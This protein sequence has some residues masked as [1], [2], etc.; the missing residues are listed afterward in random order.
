MAAVDAIILMGATGSSAVLAFLTVWPHRLDGFPRSVVLISWMLAVLAII[1]TRFSGHF[2]RSMALYGDLVGR[3]GASPAILVG[4]GPFLGELVHSLFDRPD[5]RIRPVAVIDLEGKAG[6]SRLSGIPVRGTLADL[7]SMATRR[8]AGLIIL[9]LPPWLPDRAGVVARAAA[10]SAHLGL[11]LRVVPTL[12]ESLEGEVGGLVPRPADPNDLLNRRPA[13]IDL[14]AASA[15]LTGARVLVTGASGSI[16]SELCRQVAGLAPR[17]LVLL[18]NEEN[19]LYELELELRRSLPG[20]AMAVVVAD[21]RDRAKMARVFNDLRPD[22]VFHAAAHK[23]VPLMELEPDEAVK[24]NIAGTRNVAELAVAC[25][26]KRFVFI[27]T[28]KAVNPS[29]VM[30]ASKR[31]AEHIIRSM[32]GN[33]GETRLCSV[34]FGNVLGSKGSVVPI[35]EEQIAHGRPLTITHPEMTRYFMTIPEAARLVIQAGAMTQG[36]EVFALDMGEPVKII[37]LAKNL[38]RLKGLDPD[39]DLRF[40]F[41]GVRPGEKLYEELLTAPELRTTTKHSR[42]FVARP[43]AVDRN[44]LMRDLREL[45]RLGAAVEPAMIVAKLHEMVPGYRAG[46]LFRAPPVKAE[47]KVSRRL[48]VVNRA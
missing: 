33:P 4:A 8:R 40:E 1:A 46:G 15:Y 2:F 43:D 44:R 29:S 45:E 17:L 21:I 6:G 19:G 12:R 27:S 48:R 35:F 10:V 7:E 22:V 13:E 47:S 14:E 9:A 38:A 16:G 32:H 37:D 20:Q 5:L 30:G 36:G 11:A 41:I 42:V 28:D 31:V 25:K 26:V 24:T 34:R 18:S 39:R 23:H 3:P